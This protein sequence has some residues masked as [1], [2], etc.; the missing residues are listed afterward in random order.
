MLGEVSNSS[1]T[2]DAGTGVHDGG[3][4]PLPFERGRNGG[5]GALT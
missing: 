2:R 4:I 1:V 3:I 5:A